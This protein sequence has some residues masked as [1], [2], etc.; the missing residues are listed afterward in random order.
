MFDVPLAV[1]AG[2]FRSN[3][4]PIQPAYTHTKLTKILL[5]V[6][7]IQNKSFNSALIMQTGVFALDLVDE[8]FALGFFC[9]FTFVLKTSK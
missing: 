4:L 9:E 8:Q 1:P 7:V 2:G 5:L 3:H 6:K